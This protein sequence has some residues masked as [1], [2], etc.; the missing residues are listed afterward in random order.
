M[1]LEKTR[2]IYGLDK[3]MIDLIRTYPHSEISAKVYNGKINKY[4]IIE[5]IRLDSFDKI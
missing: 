5:K 1:L 2:E 3:R 4:T